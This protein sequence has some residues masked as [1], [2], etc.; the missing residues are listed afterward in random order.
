VRFVVPDF[1]G[2]IIHLK[3]NLQIFVHL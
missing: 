1:E 2:K 3:V